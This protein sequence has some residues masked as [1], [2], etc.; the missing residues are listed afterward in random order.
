MYSTLEIQPN[1]KF[2][3]I[4]TIR[5]CPDARIR[6]IDADLAYNNG[7]FSLN[8]AAA[9]TDAKITKNLCDFD[10]PTYACIA[11]GNKIASPAGTRLPITPKFK[12]AGTARYTANVGPSTKAYGQVN[13]S[14]QGS[15][16]SEVRAGPAATIGDLP[17]F[18]TINLAF[19]LDFDKL[20]IELFASNVFD[21]RGQLSRYL[22]CGQCG[23][24]P[25]I[26]PIQP[27]TIGM[28]LG[29]DF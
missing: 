27:R 22:Q 26:V 7:G 5:T 16:S 4:V 12:L 11:G 29:Y 9:Y 10:D 6:G 15:A 20:N 19:G 23:Q 2:R 18:T 21:E 1:L 14:Y 25:Y 17:A 28:R 13:G 24:R 8:L 3:H